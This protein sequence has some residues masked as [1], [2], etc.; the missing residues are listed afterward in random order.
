MSSKDIKTMLN[1]IGYDKS[2][3]TVLGNNNWKINITGECHVQEIKDMFNVVKWEY[4]GN[5]AVFYITDGQ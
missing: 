4:E 2:L 3:V 1:Q 5:K